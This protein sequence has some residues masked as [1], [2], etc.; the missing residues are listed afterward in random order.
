MTQYFS[1]CWAIAKHEVRMLRRDRLAIVVSF[2]LPLV[3][4]IFA[5][6]LYSRAFRSNGTAGA[7]FA[8]PSMT[9]LFSFS[10]LGAI[11]ASFFN[12][13]NWGT[14]E[15]ARALPVTVPGMLVGKA[16]PVMVRSVAQQMLLLLAG[17]LI[18]GIHVAARLPYLILVSVTFSATLVAL[19]M[20]IASL[21]RT[22]QQVNVVQS[23]AMIVFGGLG[24]VLSPRSVLPAWVGKVAPVSPGYW[25]LNEYHRILVDRPGLAGLWPGIVLL[26]G[27]ACAIGAVAA[28]SFRIAAPRL[29]WG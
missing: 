5:E 28:V 16:T 14:W 4:M 18:F 27:L 19:G 26:A 22:F 1:G 17:G 21:A 23:V 6:P 15:R 8:V 3:I 24:G 7:D 13:F 10:T 29:G 9:V 25:G 20:L 2:F 11:G 12:D